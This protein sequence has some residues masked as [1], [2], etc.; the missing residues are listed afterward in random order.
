MYV[1]SLT[2]K[3]LYKYLDGESSPNKKAKNCAILR[4]RETSKIKRG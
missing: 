3:T 2:K 1:C 4:I